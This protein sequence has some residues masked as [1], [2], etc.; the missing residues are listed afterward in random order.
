MTV[1]QA[2]LEMWSDNKSQW[3]WQGISISYD[4]QGYVGQVDL[5]NRVEA[6]GGTYVLAVQN[7][8]DYVCDNCNPQG[9][10]CRLSVTWSR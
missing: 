6:S 8:N 3:W 1:T 2:I 9:I 7:S 5:S 4:R 10:A